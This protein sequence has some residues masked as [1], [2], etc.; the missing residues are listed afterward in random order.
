MTCK[1]LCMITSCVSWHA[2]H[3]FF[4]TQTPLPPSLVRNSLL[5][6]HQNFTSGTRNAYSE[7]TLETESV[8]KP[9]LKIGAFSL[10]E[11]RTEKV[12]LNNE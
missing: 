11:S 5:S 3:F 2:T 7:T 9:V 4:T 12:N 1:T 10:P 6:V 8:V